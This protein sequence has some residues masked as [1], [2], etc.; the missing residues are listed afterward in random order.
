M[1]VKLGQRQDEKEPQ[2]MQLE[3]PTM[4]PLTEPISGDDYVRVVL[5]G[6]QEA[7][8]EAWHAAHPGMYLRFPP[9]LDSFVAPGDE[10]FV[11]LRE[12]AP[13]RA[14]RPRVYRTAESLRA[15]RDEVERRM[16]AVAGE[17]STDGAVVNLSP[18]SRS[19]AARTAGR[20]RFEQM[21]RALSRY[22]ALRA[23]RDQLNGRIARA[24]ARERRAG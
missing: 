21:D 22:T 17:E 3:S 6:R 13:K 14:P 11:I 24:E 16:A 1:R 23:K 18:N 2:S 5:V 15:E 19:R 12:A 4:A 20:R 8:L 10:D 7:W 9:P